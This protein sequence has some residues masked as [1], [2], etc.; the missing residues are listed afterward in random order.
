MTCGSFGEIPK[1]CIGVI[2]G[3]WVDIWGFGFQAL[4]SLDFRIVLASLECSWLI[5]HVVYGGLGLPG[6]WVLGLRSHSFC[7]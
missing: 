1:G 4:G 5:L 2:T 6:P 3:F 7:K